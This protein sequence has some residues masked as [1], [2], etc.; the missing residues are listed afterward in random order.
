MIPSSKAKIDYDCCLKC[1]REKAFLHQLKISI[2]K[3][4]KKRFRA[5][6]IGEFYIHKGQGTFIE[7]VP[8]RKIPVNPDVTHLVRSKNF[9]KLDVIRKNNL[10]LIK[11]LV[12]KMRDIRVNEV[13]SQIESLEIEIADGA[14]LSK[15]LKE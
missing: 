11:T 15:Y 2:K 12:G 6:S 3:L 9:R 1:Y 14:D 7:D 4:K 10:D 5:I 13:L 8:Y